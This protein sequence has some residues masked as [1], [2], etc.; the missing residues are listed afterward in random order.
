M[1]IKPSA[2][3][4]IRSLVAALSDSDEVRRE[5]AVARLSV[6]GARA[7]D[8]LLTAFGGRDATDAVRLSILRTF[9][10]T[11]DPRALPP[12]RDALA[13]PALAPAAIAVLR[14]FLT[15]PASSAGTDALDALVAVILDRNRDRSL[16]LAAH[17][18]L[19]DTSADLQGRINAALLDDPDP[20]VRARVAAPADDEASSEAEWQE[21]LAGRMPNDPRL[22]LGAATTRADLTP[23]GELHR[24]IGETRQRESGSPATAV[25]WTELRGRLH[26]SLARRGSTVALYDLRESVEE[27]QG[28][29]PPS[30]TTALE[31]IGDESC[32]DGIAAAYS[33]TE[34]EP[35]RARLMRVFEVIARREKLSADHTSVK[36]IATRWPAA[37]EVFSTTLRTTP[38]RKTRGRT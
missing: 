4:E 13:S 19:R 23:F 26:E 1:A 18:A 21:V 12:V 34:D 31:L 5:T 27:A 10:A 35:W 11:A 17:E 16:R 22:L 7:T 30:F 14:A 20:V 15:A 9:E 28:P 36:R 24:I 3:A 32:L 6:I 38:R 33:R 37:F 29:L 8:R 25:D 2:S